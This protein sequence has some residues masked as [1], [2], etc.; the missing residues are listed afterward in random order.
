MILGAPPTGQDR[1]GK[2][3]WVSTE[4]GPVCSGRRCWAEPFLAVLG[5]GSLQGWAEPWALCA[6]VRVCCRGDGTDG[7][8]EDPWA[9]N[10][11]TWTSLLQYHLV[12]SPCSDP[13]Q[14]EGRFWVGHPPACP[15]VEKGH[16]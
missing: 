9:T 14:A 12:L 8:S 10:M 3:P 1:L 5:A 6:H 15:R 4:P 13:Q 11:T 2:P 16:G 7:P